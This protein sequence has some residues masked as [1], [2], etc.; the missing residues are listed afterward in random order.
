[1]LRARFQ[2]LG[3]FAFG[4]H[5]GSRRLVA[6]QV[7]YLWDDGIELTIGLLKDEDDRS[8]FVDAGLT[9]DVVGFHEV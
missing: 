3:L 5:L 6:F 9:R 1:M 7:M 4:L 2:R 8:N